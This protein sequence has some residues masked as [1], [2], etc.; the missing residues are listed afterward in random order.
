MLDGPCLSV[1]A[2]CECSLFEF[3]QKV[4]FLLLELETAVDQK[5]ARDVKMTH[6]L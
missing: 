5:Q 3:N 6:T 1:H 4:L 2:G